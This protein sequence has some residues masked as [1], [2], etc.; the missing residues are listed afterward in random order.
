MG[1]FEEYDLDSR[2]KLIFDG[3]NSHPLRPG[4]H[5]IVVD[6]DQRRTICVWASERKDDEFIYEA[7]EELIDDLPADVVKIKVSDDLELL[8]SST[9]VDDDCTKIPFYPS[10]ADFPQHLPRVRRSHLTEIDRLGVHAD[11]ATY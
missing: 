2:F 8:W 3:P 11:H 1:Y 9:N 10:P 5:H 4:Y 6:F 7:L